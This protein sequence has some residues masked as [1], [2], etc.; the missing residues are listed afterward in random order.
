MMLNNNHSF[1]LLDI[2]MSVLLLFGHCNVCPSIYRFTILIWY[3]QNVLDNLG[4]KKY[5]EEKE[6][7]TSNEYSYTFDIHVC[8]EC[9]EVNT[10]H[11][12][13]IYRLCVIQG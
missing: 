9:L 13:T 6:C 11:N 10:Q 12:L 1:S 7:P 2:V 4:R 5:V 3:L 8:Q